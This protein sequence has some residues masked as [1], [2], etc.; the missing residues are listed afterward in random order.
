MIV[1][2]LWD[3]GAWQNDASGDVWYTEHKGIAI[4]QLRKYTPRKIGWSPCYVV[5]RDNKGKE[6]EIRYP[7]PP[8]PQ[9]QV[10]IIG[11]DG[12]PVEEE[13]ITC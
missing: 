3:G 1:Y 9:W 5:V 8:I 4:I 6:R 10:R 7:T 12:Q 13:Q 11:P 2:G